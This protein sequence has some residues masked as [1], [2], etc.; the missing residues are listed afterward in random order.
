MFK[1]LRK[2]CFL[3][4]ILFS[5]NSLFAQS[6]SGI[7]KGQIID[8]TTKKPVEFAT[9]SLFKLDSSL[10]TGSIT[11][12]TGDFEINKIESGN[13]YLKVEFIGYKASFYPNISINEEQHEINIGVIKLSTF[14]ENMAE[15]E[16]VD[17][18]ELMEIKIDKKV[19]NVSKDIA[20]QGGNGLDALKNMPSVQVDEQ[21][22]ISLRGD[23]SV[24]ILID[25]RPTSIPASQLLK[26]IP[27]S[28][29]EKIE[30]VT[31]PS[32]KYR[33]EGMSGILNIVLKK[34]K[35]SGFNGNIGSGYT[36]NDNHGIF[37]YLGLNFR[38]NKINVKANVGFHKG[39]W[40]YNGV[41]DRNYFADTTYT[42]KM[43]DYGWNKNQNLWYSGGLDY[44]VNKKNTVYFEAS[45]W[46]GNNERFDNNHYD[47]ID[48]AA[49]IQTYS[50][51][52]AN[53]PSSYLGNDFNLGWQ[54]KFDKDEHTFDL[55]IDYEINKSDDNTLN[56]E[57]FYLS[58]GTE[59]RKPR[60]QNTNTLQNNTELDVKAD[61]VLPIT[62]SLKL[63]LGAR[64][65]L[66]D[67]NRDFYSESLDSLG[68]F[69][70]DMNLS[71]VFYYQQDVYAGYATLGKQYKKIGVK[72]GT[73][74]ERTIINTELKNTKEKGN[75]DYLSLFPTVH[76]SYHFTQQNEILLSYSR[77]INRPN[78]WEVNPFASYTDPYSLQTGNPNL[79]PE[80]I[81]V[82]ELGYL[83]FWEKVNFN[84]SIYFRQVNDRKQRITYLNSENV[85]VT[86]PQNISKSYIYGG[87]TTIGYR[88]YKWWRLNNT[89]N[90]WS[91]NL[92]GSS[93]NLTS[94]TYGWNFQASSDFTLK[95]GWSAQM[96]MNYDGKQ[97]TIQGETL[98]RYNVS[99]SVSKSLLKDNARIT[100]RVND[101]FRTQRWVYQ[102]NDL[103]GFSYNSNRRWASHSFHLSF[104]Y[105]FG[106][107]NYDSQKRQTKDK[108]AGD[109]LNIGSGGGNG[110]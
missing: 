87:E 13:F 59:Y 5:V 38:K 43:T 24:Q 108:S 36:Y 102:S 66:E 7:V 6:N 86:T 109:D 15:F 3:I 29:F 40:S 78:T 41:S 47:Y 32:A 103:G 2:Y 19:Y 93:G 12:S 48:E 107:M 20:N 49:V 30:V 77:R 42:Q 70:E 91:A 69:A 71:N 72:L 18:K 110:Q 88:P 61:Y 14:S 22:N 11:S 97:T 92:N 94:S 23:Q 90:I 31:N 17:E 67:I 79:K 75:Q 28:S 26:Q 96:R 58:N 82:Y 104:N 33:P 65:T 101:I 81:D 9:V 89:I 95:K 52:I 98:A 37:N 16:F 44:Y 51:R 105:S 63:E 60:G 99:A 56:D 64:I 46:N 39:T 34:E 1:Y 27:A 85:F 74:L 25:G 106:K 8:V 62:D 76:F 50:D 4:V 80:Y 35:A 55:D 73:R 10:V 21:D 53:S 83:R 45:G 68:A 57:H 100:F 84:S 54:T